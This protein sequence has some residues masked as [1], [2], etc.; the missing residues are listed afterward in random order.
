[1]PWKKEE[2]LPEVKT[3]EHFKLKNSTEYM[4]NK[5]KSNKINT[6]I[7]SSHLTV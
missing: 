1:M 6:A 3:T 4:K 2:E 7:T 5:Y